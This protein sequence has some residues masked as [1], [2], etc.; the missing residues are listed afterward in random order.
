MI[1]MLNIFLLYYILLSTVCPY[2]RLKEFMLRIVPLDN[3]NNNFPVSISEE[4]S[5]NPSSDSNFAAERQ[6]LL[7]SRHNCSHHPKNG[8]FH[9]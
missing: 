6:G 9:G 1:L 5:P 3:S 8:L 4:L 7:L 2:C